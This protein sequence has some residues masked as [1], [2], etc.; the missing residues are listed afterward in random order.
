[1]DP[2]LFYGLSDILPLARAL[3]GERIKLSI[4]TDDPITIY[5]DSISA[6]SV[7]NTVPESQAPNVGIKPSPLKT[8]S[9]GSTFIIEIWINDIPG[10]WGMFGWEARAQRFQRS[11]R[12][13]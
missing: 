10:G 6:P 12:G 4:S 11:W 2:G 9:P 8:A 7:L 13:P 3:N 5:Y 1:M